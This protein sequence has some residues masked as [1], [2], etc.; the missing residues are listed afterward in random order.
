MDVTPD[1]HDNESTR[2]DRWRRRLPDADELARSRWL[3]WLGPRLHS[4]HL[5]RI[6]RRGVALG[7]AIGTFFGLLVPLAQI[8]LS[9][10][11][12]IA[13]RAHLPTALASTLVSNPVTFAPLYYL[14]YRVGAALLGD[15]TVAAVEVPLGT[16]SDAQGEPAQ[17]EGPTTRSA[18]MTIMGMGRPLLLGLAIVSCLGAALVYAVVDIGWRLLEWRARRDRTRHAA[19]GPGKSTHDADRLADKSPPS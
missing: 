13:L 7:A 9:A 10:S 5:W 11:L 2:F 15:V 16:E 6:S 3:R 19:S 8:P 1:R 4:P 14:A 18:Q 17:H 12:A